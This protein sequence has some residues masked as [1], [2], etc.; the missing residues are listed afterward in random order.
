MSEN[1]KTTPVYAAGTWVR[2][3]QFADGGEI[4]KLSVLVDKFTEFL[5]ANKK[6]DGFVNL[7]IQ[8]KREPDDKSSHSVKLD[9]W[10]PKTQ[11]GQVAPK[12]QSEPAVKKTASESDDDNMF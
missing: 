12:V 8:K 4:L 3:H 2:S 7:V 1:N 10:V 9:N 6:D 11:S 5:Q